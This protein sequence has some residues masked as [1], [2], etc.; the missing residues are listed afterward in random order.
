MIVFT[1]MADM[2]KAVQALLECDEIEVLRVKD[3]FGNPTS[4]G[5][6]DVMINFKLKGDPTHH[7]CEVQ[8]VL[9]KLLVVRT[10]LG[11]HKEYAVL[12][13]AVELQEVNAA[14]IEAAEAA[15][16]EAASHG[17]F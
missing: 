15:A 7:I 10:Q 11:G 14:S 9:E 13:S 2:Q 12:R 16:A 1:K 5:W 8:L 4:G 3:R 17:E 6:R